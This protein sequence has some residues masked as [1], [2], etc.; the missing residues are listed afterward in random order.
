MRP[1][2]NLHFAEHV[3]EMFSVSPQPPT[4]LHVTGIRNPKT[5]ALEHGKNL[6]PLG[7]FQRARIHAFPACRNLPV[8]V[9]RDEELARISPQL[10]E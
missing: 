4:L 2:K 5:G 1:S 8:D 3:A 9:V 6:I 10:V 7:A